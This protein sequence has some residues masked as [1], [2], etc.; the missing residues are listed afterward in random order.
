M[1]LTVF[2]GAVLGFIF[3][4][5]A[6]YKWPNL[7]FYLLPTRAWEMMMGGVAYLYPFAL[8][9]EKKKLLEYFGLVLII[10]SYFLIS[11]DN[12]WP[13][14]LALL[15]VLGS[16]FII[17]AQ[18]QDS[19]LTS[20][21]VFQKIGAWSYSI[22]LWHWPL[23][24][25]IYYFSLNEKYIYFGV[26]LSGLLGFL[27]S[28]YIERIKFRNNFTGVPD[29]LKCKPIL[30][31]GFVIVTSFLVYMFEPNK[32]LYQ[33]PESVLK[34]MERRDYE[35]FDQEFLHRKD[36]DFCKIT[37]GD[38]KLFAFGDS[39]LY[40]SLPAIEFV[41]KEL[42]Y[43]LTYAGYSGCP[44][45][46][47]VYPHRSDQNNKNCN[48]LNEKVIKYITDQKIDYVFLAARWSYYTEGDYLGGGIQYLLSH[49]DEYVSRKNSL[50]A[51]RKGLNATFKMYSR[52]EAKVVLMLQVPMQ[53]KHPK[54]IYY[55]SIVSEKVKQVLLNT[56]SV[57]MA[58]H[59]EFQR[60][61]NEIISEEAQKFSNIILI[62]ATKSMCV[63][64]V[65]PVGDEFKSYYFDDDHLSIYG[66]NKLKEILIDSIK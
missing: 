58:K 34:S 33:I 30:L 12:L 27:S 32:Y 59:L 20:N 52:T 11:K 19:F 35:C 25:A 48:I 50:S 26:A 54:N 40:S 28:E 45:L 39:H 7:A 14:Y 44:P 47:N 6:T 15:P 43:E 23:V 53:E 13:G 56:S 57:S 18:R 49:E 42:G 4:T 62:D 65:C 51:F 8:K 66:N 31:A 41:S 21:M 63:D 29:Y 64:Q 61:T 46:I 55:N 3:C 38:K 17:Q 2:L 1:K 10:L 60:K 24:V 16:F 37:A 22:Y 9:E 36:N 5:I